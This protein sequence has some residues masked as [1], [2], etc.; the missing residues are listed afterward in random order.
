M[1]S[2]IKKLKNAIPKPL[3]QFSREL[4]DGLRFRRDIGREVPV[5]VYQM[6]KVGSSSVYRSL[7][8]QYAGVV[9]HSHVFRA[10][11]HRPLVRRLYDHV[12]V[13]SQPL[14][15]ISLTREPV[16][17]NVS[18]FFQNFEQF[19]GVP[20]QQ[21]EFSVEELRDIFLQNY[22]H[23]IPLTWF[24]NNI[25]SNFGIDVFS[26]PFRSNGIGRYH[27]R[28]I[29][30]LVLRLEMTD[31]EKVA[32]IQDFL[33][34]D[35]FELIN[36]NLGAKKLY[37]QAYNEFRSRIK[38]PLEY[39]EKMYSSNYFQHFYGKEQ[40]QALIDRWAGSGRRAA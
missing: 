3:R 15:V 26:T 30:L 17:R 33:E 35:H 18:A 27:N 40:R 2:S 37:S 25:L 7:S 13:N 11:H 31:E 39:L 20:F 29:D 1:I 8:S 14:K 23:R 4:T 28:N 34:L 5:L 12:M 19:T 22:P 24:D 9:G 6:G 16:G 32:A 21:S 38:L 36:I 10:D